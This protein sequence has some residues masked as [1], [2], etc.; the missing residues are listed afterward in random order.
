MEDFQHGYPER[1]ELFEPTLA[2]FPTVFRSSTVD[3]ATLIVL[4]IH[5]VLV[6]SSSAGGAQIISLRGCC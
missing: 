6:V 1:T 3:Q 5:G 4:L 2:G